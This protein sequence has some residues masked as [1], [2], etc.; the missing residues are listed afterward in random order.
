MTSTTADADQG[1]LP[2]LGRALDTAVVLLDTDPAAVGAARAAVSD[3]CADYLSSSQMNDAVLVVSEM[4]TNAQKHGGSPVRLTIRAHPCGVTI[5]VVDGRSGADAIARITSLVPPE[6]K[7][8]GMIKDMGAVSVSGRGLF[9]IDVLAT[10][11]T[12]GEATDGGTEV[13]AVFSKGNG[14]KA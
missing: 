14:Q 4:V 5:G 7:A 9:M 8:E 6:V 12:V 1:A 11:W 13:I 2:D 3:F 10:A